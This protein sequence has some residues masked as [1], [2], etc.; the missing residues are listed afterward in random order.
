MDWFFRLIGIVVDFLIKLPNPIAQEAY[1][2]GRADQA[3]AT[4]AKTTEVTL[5]EL[6]AV[7]DSKPTDTIDSL[8]KGTF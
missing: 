7:V 4:D 5:A 6:K 8:H 1:K 3:A 2:A